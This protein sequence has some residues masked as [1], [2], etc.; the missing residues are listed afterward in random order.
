MDVKEIPMPARER[1]MIP[2]NEGEF[3]AR[4]RSLVDDTEDCP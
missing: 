1:G 4:K 2:T 3:E